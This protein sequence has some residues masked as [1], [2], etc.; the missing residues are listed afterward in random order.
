MEVHHHSHSARKKWTHYI[1]EF[2]MLFLAV[3]CGFLAEYKLEHTIEHQREK[4][5]AI[6]LLDEINSV[7]NEIPDATA[8]VKFKET[9]CDSMLALLKG[10]H[11]GN[12]QWQ[13]IYAYCAVADIYSFLRCTSTAV[14]QLK[15]S[16]SIRYFGNATLVNA[17]LA[18]VKEL[19][20]VS[21]IQQDLINYYNQQFT[22]FLIKNFDRE[23]ATT[24]YS[25][26]NLSADSIANYKEE[27]I[28]SYLS[29]DP[30][31]DIE[32]KNHLFYIWHS[33]GLAGRYAT[34]S[35]RAQTL[36]QL[37]KKEYHLK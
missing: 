2:L 16:G 24:L 26:Y 12:K 31:P 22:P 23:R 32:L 36:I 14:D 37:L 5:S 1:W 29:G 7:D 18:Y 13:K 34:L 17:F 4:V 21:F 28:P 35:T 3:F 27:A 10:Q 6:Q 30:H 33:Y 20:D 19:D 9:V 8:S 15:N 25:R 11:T